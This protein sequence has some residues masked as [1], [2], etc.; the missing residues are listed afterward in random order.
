MVLAPECVNV[1]G[2]ALFATIG[3]PR[4]VSYSGVL[5]F[6]DRVSN[7]GFRRTFLDFLELAGFSG[8]LCKVS[9]GF[10]V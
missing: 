7:F 9:L 8:L 6:F 1:L 5:R 3:P 10:F 2:R 4:L